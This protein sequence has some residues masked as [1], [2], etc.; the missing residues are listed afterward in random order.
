MGVGPGQPA[1]TASQQSG[2][3]QAL[4]QNGP[5]QNPQ[6]PTERNDP[7]HSWFLALQRVRITLQDII[8]KE[9][10]DKD[11]V[12][13]SLL[14]AQHAALEKL[15]AGI[16]PHIVALLQAASVV[17]SIS[18]QIAS[19]L[20]IQAAQQGRPPQVPGAP[21]IVGMPQSPLGGLPMAPPTA[22]PQGASASPP[23]FGG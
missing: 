21:S 12:T 1:M 23:A 5:P 13:Q 7:K 3:R 6:T 16:D 17:K 15:L 20:E 14:V 22:A 18:P 19:Q 8:N 4:S 2:L 10:D 11:E 9:L